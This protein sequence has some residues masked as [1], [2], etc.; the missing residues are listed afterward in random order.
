MAG[1]NISLSLNKRQSSSDK[2]HNKSLG[3]VL[4]FP[5]RC[6]WAGSLPFSLSTVKGKNRTRRKLLLCFLSELLCLS[7]KLKL[8]L[9]LAILLKFTNF[10]L[11]IE[12]KQLRLRVHSVKVRQSEHPQ[13]QLLGQRLAKGSLLSYFLYVSGVSV[14]IF[15]TLWLCLCECVLQGPIRLKAL[16]VD[17]QE[18]A[19]I[20]ACKHDIVKGQKK[21]TLRPPT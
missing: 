3:L 10:Q 2:K 8:I 1:F 12:N 19:E 9:K 17:G 18:K 11:C 20:L 6:C 13:A 21:G 15:V 14:C 16:S 5:F 7:F 4:F